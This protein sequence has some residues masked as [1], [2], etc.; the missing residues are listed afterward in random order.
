MADELVVLQ[1]TV[2]IGDERPPQVPDLAAA[3][4]RLDVESVV[5]RRVL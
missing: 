2:R 4:L 1:R 5:S 3:D